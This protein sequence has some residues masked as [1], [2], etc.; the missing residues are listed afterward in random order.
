M[1]GLSLTGPLTKA[2][3]R[4]IRAGK[5][6]VSKRLTITTLPAF[7]VWQPSVIVR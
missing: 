1:F 7:G 5:W 6:P 2:D 3:R 4:R